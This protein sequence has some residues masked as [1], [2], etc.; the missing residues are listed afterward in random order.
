[1]LS[2][3]IRGGGK[4][5]DL[6]LMTKVHVDMP[7][8]LAV[9]LLQLS[10]GAQKAQQLQSRRRSRSR[11]SRHKRMC[12][13]AELVRQF[14]AGVHKTF[15]NSGSDATLAGTIH[16]KYI[17]AASGTGTGDVFLPEALHPKYNNDNGD[18]RN[19]TSTATKIMKL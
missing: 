13:W 14:T 4:E 15:S 11:I 7:V 5:I 2:R 16:Q 3:Q 17:F 6:G 12:T 18:I 8:D 1:M 10:Y 9:L 19:F